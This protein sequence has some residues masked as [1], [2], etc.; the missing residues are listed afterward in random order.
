MDIID[1]INEG[2]L[3]HSHTLHCEGQR[4]QLLQ[5]MRKNKRISQKVQP[6]SI[7][8][9]MSKEQLIQNNNESGPIVRKFD[10]KKK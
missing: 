6:Q 5:E 8:L 2:V 10:T 4:P 9:I 7:S 1:L 3:M